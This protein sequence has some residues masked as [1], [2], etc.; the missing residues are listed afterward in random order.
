MTQSEPP[1]GFREGLLAGGGSG[2]PEVYAA[3]YEDLKRAAHLQLRRSA[4]AFDTTALVNETFLKLSSSGSLKPEDRRQLLALSARA[5]R[6][7]LVDE[8]R[9]LHAGKRDGGEQITLVTQMGGPDPAFDVLEVDELLGTLADADPRAAAVVELRCFGGYN[10][11]EIAD[12]LEVTSRT[13]QRDW[14]KARAFL[15]A[16]LGQ[17]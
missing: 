12:L 16:Q 6:N 4:R 11:D 1:A 10:E 2:W 5:M 7:V 15:V 3:A 14:R 8:V 17:G 9:R 13:V